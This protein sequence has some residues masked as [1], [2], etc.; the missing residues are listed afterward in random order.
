MTDPEQSASASERTQ[1]ERL[2][3][4]ILYHR[5]AAELLMEEGNLA[6]RRDGLAGLLSVAPRS[7]S[8]SSS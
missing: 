3:R 5:M 7:P 6:P 8:P 4:A 1:N 2:L